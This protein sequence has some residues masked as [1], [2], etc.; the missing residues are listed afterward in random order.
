MHDRETTIRELIKR[1]LKAT[2]RSPKVVFD[3]TKPEGAA[4]KS[5]DVTKL[6]TV[7]HGFTPQITLDEGLVEMIPY[8]KD[9]FFNG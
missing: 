6:R 3:T 8:L 9:K 4:R 5:A 7:T 1:I 2:V